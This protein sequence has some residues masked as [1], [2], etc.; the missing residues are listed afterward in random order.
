MKLVAEAEGVEGGARGEALRLC[1]A[2]RHPNL[3]RRPSLPHRASGQASKRG[4]EREICT[5]SGRYR[6]AE[7]CD[8]F[9]TKYIS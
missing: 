4:R 2:T 1:L 8:L 7:L 3:V 9:F 5:M 6:A